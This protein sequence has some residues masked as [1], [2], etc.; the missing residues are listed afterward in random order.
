[1]L[2][3]NG[4]LY[5]LRS[6]HS[7]FACVYSQIATKNSVTPK[8]IATELGLSGMLSVFISFFLL[9]VNSIRMQKLF[10]EKRSKR[11]PILL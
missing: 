4:Q 9:E 11:S 2:T 1:M 5:V 3:R 6:A 8:H 10:E 7:C